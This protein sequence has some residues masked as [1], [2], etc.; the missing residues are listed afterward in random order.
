MYES[1]KICIGRMRF[2]EEFLHYDE[3]MRGV[4]ERRI[5]NLREI[6]HTDYCIYSYST[7]MCFVD[8]DKRVYSINPRK[9]SVTTSKQVSYILE[10]A[11]KWEMR[12][13]ENI[14]WI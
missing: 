11:K 14:L 10:A 1:Y 12:G 5:I 2:F 7:L 13:F 8:L 9:Y 4:K 6:Y 3:N